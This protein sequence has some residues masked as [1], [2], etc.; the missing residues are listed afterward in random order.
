M[1]LLTLARRDVRITL[2]ATSE[3]AHA[4]V[5]GCLVELGQGQQIICSRLFG[6]CGGNGKR[7]KVQILLPAA[8][9][10][11][12]AHGPSLPGAEFAGWS[13]THT[14]RLST[15]VSVSGPLETHARLSL[16]KTASMMPLWRRLFNC[17][18]PP[19]Y[20]AP[21]CRTGF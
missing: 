5:R 14:A 11:D 3:V 18:S 16:L 2:T 7:K 20:A 9:A 15:H 4:V 10:R 6:E 21:R 12:S 1:G 17:P 19:A 8:R 13:R